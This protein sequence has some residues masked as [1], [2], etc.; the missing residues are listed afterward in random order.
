MHQ[1]WT[2][3]CTTGCQLTLK[4]ALHT[5]VAVVG[6]QCARTKNVLRLAVRIS[7]VVCCLLSPVIRCHPPDHRRTGLCRGC[8]GGTK[9]RALPGCLGGWGAPLATMAAAYGAGQTIIADSKSQT[10]VPMANSNRSDNESE[11]HNAYGSRFGS[12]VLLCLADGILQ[13]LRWL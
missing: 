12:P 7:C 10:D 2:A 5:A 6:R 11:E 9:P 4:G 13:L 3:Q 1:S 8:S